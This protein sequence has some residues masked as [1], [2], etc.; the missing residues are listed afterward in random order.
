MPPKVHEGEVHLRDAKH[1]AP[2]QPSRPRPG[3]QGHLLELQHQ[4]PV[5]AVRE[6][7]LCRVHQGP[8]LGPQGGVRGQGAGRRCGVDDGPGHDARGHELVGDEALN[9]APR[10]AIVVGRLVYEHVLGGG[11]VQRQG[12]HPRQGV[13]LVHA[14]VV[15]PEEHFAAPIA[16][17]VPG[18][19]P[20]EGR[21][22]A[23]G[24]V[25]G[26]ALL[27]LE[28]AVTYE[29]DHAAL[30]EGLPGV[31]GARRGAPRDPPRALELSRGQHTHG[32]EARGLDEVQAAP[33]A[34]HA[35]ARLL[36]PLG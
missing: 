9:L 35:R 7:A 5:P 20:G 32:R 1:H 24:R 28:P 36:L 29:D 12:A 33:G 17:L 10:A 3:P 6:R 4:G 16:A 11:H 8:P 19:K 13:P 14:G 18:G 21:G 23:L 25:V 30:A 31:H 34:L 22:L 27:G 2:L 15:H 26:E